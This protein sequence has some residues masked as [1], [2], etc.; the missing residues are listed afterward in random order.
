MYNFRLS[1]NAANTTQYQGMYSLRLST[2]AAIHILKKYFS[3]HNFNECR[4]LRLSANLYTDNPQN[5]MTKT[6]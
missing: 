6:N 2:N 4:I 3:T 1:A 5:K